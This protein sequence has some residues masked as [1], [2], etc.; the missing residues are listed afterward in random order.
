MFCRVSIG[1]TVDVGRES[2]FATGPYGTAKTAIVGYIHGSALRLAG[3]G[4]L[5]PPGG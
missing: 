5:V 2:D 4:T 1:A 3:L